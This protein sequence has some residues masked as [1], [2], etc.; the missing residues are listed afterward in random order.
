MTRIVPLFLALKN[1]ETANRLCITSQEKQR[2]TS[3][4]MYS[5]RMSSSFAISLLRKPS[6]EAVCLE[7]VIQQ[8][9]EDNNGAWTGLVIVPQGLIKAF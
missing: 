8:M 6:I 4:R 5:L 3:N 9:Q 1:V 7:W 2:I